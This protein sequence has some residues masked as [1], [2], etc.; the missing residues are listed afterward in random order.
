MITDT[1]K[2]T[3]SEN[4]TEKSDVCQIYPDLGQPE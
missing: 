1:P 4:T 3:G 2:D